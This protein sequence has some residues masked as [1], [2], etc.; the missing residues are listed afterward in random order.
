MFFI[1]GIFQTLFYH[2]FQPSG[3]ILND[4]KYS[5]TSLF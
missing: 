3:V 2:V 1:T 5:N 4:E